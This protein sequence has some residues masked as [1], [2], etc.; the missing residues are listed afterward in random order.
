MRNTMGI[1]VANDERIPPVT[2]KRSVSALP[3]AGSYRI[4]DFVISNMARAG[5]INVGVVTD[6]N[7]SSLMDH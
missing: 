2:D 4:I 6:S 7:Y 1:I 5:I 3:I